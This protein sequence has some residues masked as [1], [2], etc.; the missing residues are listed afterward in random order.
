MAPCP[1][2]AGSASTWCSASSRSMAASRAGRAAD[3]AARA[4][5]QSRRSRAAARERERDGR[6]KVA[7]V[8]V[9]SL[10][11]AHE[12]FEG[13]RSIDPTVTDIHALFER[14]GRYDID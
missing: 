3:R 4:Q 11:E 12:F 7:I 5:A 1:I 9:D 14:D 10:R 2:A 8:G 13:L 6:D